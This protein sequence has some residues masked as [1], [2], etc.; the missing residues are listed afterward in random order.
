MT[1]DQITKYFE[2]TE[3][4]PKY[5]QIDTNT[6]FFY[7]NLIKK[8]KRHKIGKGDR[9]MKTVEEICLPKPKKELKYFTVEG[10]PGKVIDPKANKMSFMCFSLFLPK[11]LHFETKI[12]SFHTFL[13]QTLQC[14]CMPLK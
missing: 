13:L 3:D 8:V 10:V 1:P 11:K 9:G 2:N 7:D 5:K 12:Y 6:K 4:H 14:I